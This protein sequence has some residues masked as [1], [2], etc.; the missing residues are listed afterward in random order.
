MECSTRESC[1]RN[2]ALSVAFAQGIRITRSARTA[3]RSAPILRVTSGPDRR[4]HH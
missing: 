3:Y 2:A 1:E 4:L